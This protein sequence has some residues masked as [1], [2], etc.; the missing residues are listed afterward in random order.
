MGDS[1]SRPQGGGAPGDTSV[2]PQ[3]TD[4]STT[5]DAEQQL[6]QQT[7]I[8]LRAVINLLQEK[9]GVNQDTGMGG[10][11][12]TG[13]MGGAPDSNSDS[14]DISI[15][16]TY[17]VN[18]EAVTEDGK[19]YTADNT[20]ESAILVTNGGNLTVTN[21]TITTT[22]DTSS[23]DNSSFYGQNA[24]VLAQADS[25]ITMSSSTITTSGKGANGAFA[26]GENSLVT[27][28]NVTI[29]A[30]GDGG[31]AVM[32]TQ[33]GSMVLKNVD[34]TTTGGSSS[35][36][37]TDRGSGTI[38]VAGG[39]VN[40]SG[41]NSAGLYSTRV[42]NVTQATITATG[43]EAAVI[44][45]GNTITLDDT[46]L[47]S[48][49]EGKWGVMIY[50]SM[51]GDAEGTEGTFTMTGGSLAYSS[52]TGPLFYVTNSTGNINLKNVSLVTGSGE[53]IRAEAGNWGIDGSN[54]GTVILTADAQILAGNVIADAISSVS[55]TLQ[56][57]SVWTG[58]AN[59]DKT[60][61]SINI[62]L[63]E[64]S[65]W[66]LTADSYVTTFC[67]T[68]GISGT[69]VT[70]VNGNGF[71]IYYDTSANPTLNGQTYNLVGGGA[72]TPSS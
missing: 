10:N 20:D 58:A 34:M 33:G 4:Q 64:S 57:G 3:S 49:Y 42:I 25:T 43:A 38:T 32:A 16:A 6:T 61:K 71:S 41:S 39:T 36:I 30:S 44:E 50:Q 14:S 1:G 27:L 40:T 13:D 67:D 47:S 66:T 18:G 8:L 11:A 12:P 35:A 51:S 59:T 7:S 54:G 15:S 26:T 9:T 69:S 53:L 52:T 60:A 19:A 63:D 21:A 70:N 55:M 23:S 72:L 28:T 29:T 31:H 48:S 65:T 45:G 2:T 62:S 17:T 56:N 24:A 5:A 46:I 22:G 68:A 37:A